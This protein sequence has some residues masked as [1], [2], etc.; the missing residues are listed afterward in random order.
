MTDWDSWQQAPHID[1]TQIRGN[2]ADAEK[3]SSARSSSHSTPPGAGSRDSRHSAAKS[4][5]ASRLLS[6]TYGTI[7]PLGPPRARWSQRSRLRR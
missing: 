2:I 7:L 6:S 5:R 4:R 3:N 1:A